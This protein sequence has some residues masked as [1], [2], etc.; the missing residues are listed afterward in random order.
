MK[1]L[2]SMVVAFSMYS[3]IPMPQ[4]QWKKDNMRFA[5]TIGTYQY[6]GSI[7]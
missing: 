4:I 7:R 1:L 3:K 6:S 2:E 5:F